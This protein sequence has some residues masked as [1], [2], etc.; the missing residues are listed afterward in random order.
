MNETE[1][2]DG[3]AS[4]VHRGA[5]PHRQ[6]PAGS[7]LLD[8]ARARVFTDTQDQSPTPNSYGSPG[9]VKRS[10]LSLPP[11]HVQVSLN[12]PILQLLVSMDLLV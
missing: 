5:G 8:M 4:A 7:M 12:I 3:M 9:G 10:P 6:L 11:A 1:Q 2:I